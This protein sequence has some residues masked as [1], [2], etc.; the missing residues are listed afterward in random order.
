MKTFIFVLVMAAMLSLVSCAS[1]STTARPTTT[2]EAT[3][4]QPTTTQ[5]TTVSGGGAAKI[6]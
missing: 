3:L 2:R 5:Q 4:T 6:R 1:E